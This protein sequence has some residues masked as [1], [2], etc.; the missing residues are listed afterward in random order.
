VPITEGDLPVNIDRSAFLAFV[1]SM[2]SVTLAHPGDAQEA[3]QAAASAPVAVVPGVD[4]LGVRIGMSSSQASAALKKKGVNPVN[5]GPTPN[6]PSVE[7]LVGWAREADLAAPDSN[8]GVHLT[9]TSPQV[10]HT[11][12]HAEKKPL[13]ATAVASA[14]RSKYGAHGID[15]GVAPTKE[16][17]RVQTKESC[18]K[19]FVEKE[20]GDCKAALARKKDTN[21]QHLQ[22]CVEQREKACNPYPAAAAQPLTG[23]H[24]ILWRYDEHGR[25]LSQEAFDRYCPKATP[26]SPC[27]AITVLA[28][29]GSPDAVGAIQ[30]YLV[31]LRSD[32]LLKHDS[33]EQQRQRSEAQA[34]AE[35]KRRDQELN[36]ARQN[37]PQ[38]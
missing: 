29:F 19:G 23:G 8:L 24:A 2:A 37:Q 7:G 9:R 5:V 15:I 1:A 33:D 32:W 21:P 10:V 14:L 26:P 36:V 18:Q 12:W 4:V 31:Q 22:A 3:A 35:K 34:A 25:P 17:T 38:L 13:L 6:G 16:F 11:V 20:G 30:G 28:T 27:K